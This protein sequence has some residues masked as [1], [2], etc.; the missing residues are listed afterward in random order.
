MSTP[1]PSLPLGSI[2][3]RMRVFGD[4]GEELARTMA[5]P[6]P[7][8]MRRL[9]ELHALGSS[10][11]DTVTGE[12]GVSAALA[13]LQ[14]RLKQRLETLVFVSGHLE[15]LGWGIELSGPD[16]IAHKVTVPQTA[17][18]ALAAH[19]LEGAL[20]AVSDLDERGQFRLYEPWE[21]WAG[22]GGRGG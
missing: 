9:F 5:P 2:A 20:V 12:V 21:L 18:E 19:Q 6:W 16:L 10:H 1:A 17:R 3:I 15:E 8:W 11:V 22:G 14:V 13:A 4:A 7:R